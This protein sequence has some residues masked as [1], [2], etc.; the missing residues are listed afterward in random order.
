MASFSSKTMFMKQVNPQSFI[1]LPCQKLVL[2]HTW[3][4]GDGASYVSSWSEDAA[5]CSRWLSA[6]LL[7]IDEVAAAGDQQSLSC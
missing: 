4:R 3:N 5:A 2:D 7:V 6:R 1:L